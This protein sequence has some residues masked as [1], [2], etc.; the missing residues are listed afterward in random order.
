MGIIHMK[1]RTLCSRL[2]GILIKCRESVGKA[3]LPVGP[4]A[5]ATNMAWA[6]T[7]GHRTPPRRGVGRSHHFRRNGRGLCGKANNT[8]ELLATNDLGER[9]LASPAV[10]DG[11]ERALRK[12]HPLRRCV[13][14][15]IVPR[16]EY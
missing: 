2:S 5:T 8:Y 16:F 9:S 10:A 12:T 7:K 1:R 3:S 11:A 4:V 6:V 13:V 14:S 15:L